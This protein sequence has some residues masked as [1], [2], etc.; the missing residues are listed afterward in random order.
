MTGG[1][2]EESIARRAD[3]PLLWR[4]ARGEV[5]S[6][7]IKGY[8]DGVGADAGKAF[9]NQSQEALTGNMMTET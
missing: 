6:Q 2:N 3:S 9:N 5:F 1:I 4:A 7:A 8:N